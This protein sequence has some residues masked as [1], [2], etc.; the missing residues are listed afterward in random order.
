MSMDR[1]R[2]QFLVTDGSRGKGE[3][4]LLPLHEINLLLSRG[5]VKLAPE[6]K[7]EPPEIKPVG[8]SEVKPAAPS[9]VKNTK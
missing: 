7:P 5:A 9:Q 6:G 3:F 4:Y 8:P 1:K 2:V